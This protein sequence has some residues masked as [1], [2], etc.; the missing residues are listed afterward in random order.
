[1]SSTK[2]SIPKLWFTDFDGTIKPFNQK[3]SKEDFIALDAIG[4]KGGIRV[5][6]TGR[7][8]RTFEAEWDKDLH[9]DY[10]ISSAGLAVS[11]FGKEGHEKIL[12]SHSFTQEDSALAVKTAIDLNIGFCF[13]F[14]PPMAHAFYYKYPETFDPPPSFVAMVNQA[15]R[16][17]TPWRGELEFALGQVLLIAEPSLLKEKAEAF[18][19]VMPWISFVFTSSPYGDGTL[20]LEVYPPG[21][22][23]GQSAQRLAKSL[24]VDSIDCV[25][26]GNDYN[27]TDLLS[28]AGISFISSTGPS[29]MIKSYKNMPPAGS[30]P[31]RY[32]LNELCPGIYDAYVLDQGTR[33]GA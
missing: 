21:I 20:W 12:E 28:W 1:M 32:V 3:V 30:A 16:E 29:D 18:K 33:I 11:K 25:A 4:A 14:P 24:K 22:S 7:S 9:I 31:V 15:D 5:V 2:L 8:I 6:A 19:K 17:P 26:L 13:C 27:D 10:L 23:K